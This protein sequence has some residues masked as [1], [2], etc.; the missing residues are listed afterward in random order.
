MTLWCVANKSVK[1]ISNIL[2]YFGEIE[3]RHLG[4]VDEGLER[5]REL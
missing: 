1:L 3:E 2:H 5:H 4:R